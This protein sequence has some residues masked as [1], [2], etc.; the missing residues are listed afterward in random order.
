VP[1]DHDQRLVWRIAALLLDYPTAETCLLIDQMATAT[2]QLAEP[3]GSNITDFLLYFCRTEPTERAARHL[4]TFDV[5]HRSRL[6]L[7]YYAHGTRKRDLALLRLKQAYRQAAFAISDTDAPD[8][9][10]LVLE[11]AATADHVVGQRLLADHAS[12]LELLRVSLHAGD[13]PYA[14]LL[15]AVLA[16]LP[17]NAAAERRRIA[18][19]T[20]A[21]STARGV[22]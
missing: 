22:A 17:S 6:H 21:G 2:G 13:S 5:R 16:T 15:A 7:T 20:A 9:L 14:G 8:Y 18:E 10:P 11:F 12:A 4:E 1:A 19:L 3:V